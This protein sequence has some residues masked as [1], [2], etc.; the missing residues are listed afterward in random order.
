VALELAA[1]AA[2]GA[3]IA[4][5]YAGPLRVELFG[6]V[7]SL[8]TL[9][10]PLLVAVALLCARLWLV[11]GRHRSI[12]VARAATGVL[13][14]ALMTAGIIGWGTYLSPTVG[15][16]DSYGYVSTA[17]RLLARELVVPEPLATVLPFADG[18]VAATP[19]G[20]MPA[21][22]VANASAPMYPLGLPVLMAAAQAMAGRAAPFAVAPIMGLVLLLAARQ[23]ALAWY[24]DRDVA[25]VACALLALHPLVFT[26]SLQPM[27]DV[28][29][30][31]LMMVAIAAISRQSHA[32]AGCA[33]GAAVLIRPA[34]APAAILLALLPIARWWWTSRSEEQTAARPGAGRTAP[35]T[36]RPAPAILL[37]DTAERVLGPA[38]SSGRYLGPL[39]AAIALLAWTQWYLYG[40]PLSSGY[41]NV[42]GL[43]SVATAAE[44]VRS[45]AYWGF[46]T[47][48]PLWLVATAA[49]VALSGATA[50]LVL[51]LVAA[52]VAIPYVF[53]RPYDHWETLRFLL[54]ALAAATVVAAAGLVGLA[55]RIAGEAGGGL[56]A[57]TA[58]GFIVWGWVGWMAAQQVFT[59]PQHEA[60]HRLAAQLVEHAAP[61]DAIVLALQHSG[62]LRYYTARSTVNWDAVPPGA[63]PATVKALQRHGR[64]V[65]LMIDSAA[66]REMF[67]ARHGGAL[68]SGDWLPSGQRRSVQLYEAQPAP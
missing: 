21:V 42:G 45:Y 53:Y 32:R 56:L 5:A 19:L 46:V 34:L 6:S 47:L 30:T 31:A 26:Y 29:A 13:T 18:I 36:H 64:A 61:P 20:Y 60:R 57:A 52:G 1:A 54:P 8:R 37:R 50:R 58:A 65:F 51:A 55:R 17:E 59:M 22:R 11:R 62:S 44:N 12:Q 68:D 2:I 67:E 28:P 43:F 48:G 10:R 14:G 49:G 63:L 41:G 40:H 23:T 3:A 25:R 7:L 15:G 66:E 4:A 33:A 27:S 38:R 24:Q 35:G 16:A 9:S 39:A